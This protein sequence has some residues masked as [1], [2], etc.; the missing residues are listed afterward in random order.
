MYHVPADQS[1]MRF[2]IHDQQIPLTFYSCCASITTTYRRPV[3]N[4]NLPMAKI[5]LKY[6]V[7]DL[8]R[9]VFGLRNHCIQIE[10]I[11]HGFI[12]QI[13]WN[14]HIPHISTN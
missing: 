5:S 13:W 12:S 4:Q 2:Y 6:Q 10:V 1:A 8:L 7:G 14:D 11:H 3:E 9:R